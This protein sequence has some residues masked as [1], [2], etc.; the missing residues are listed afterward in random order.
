[1]RPIRGRFMMAAAWNFM[2]IE[3][4]ADDQLI[5]PMIGPGE[6][7]HHQ[8]HTEIQ[9]LLD[10]HPDLAAAAAIWRRGAEDDTVYQGPFICVLYQHPTGQDPRRGAMDWLED[11]AATMRTTGLDIQVAAFPDR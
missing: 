8:A 6:L 10:A 2:L 5:H 1:M 11:L 3:L 7:T 4:V 9:T